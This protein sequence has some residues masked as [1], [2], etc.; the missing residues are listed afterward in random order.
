MRLALPLLQKVEGLSFFK[1]LG[2]G[3]GDGFSLWPD[4]STYAHLMV[5]DSWQDANIYFGNHA[6][7]QDYINNSVDHGIIYLK[8]VHGHGQWDGQEPFQMQKD[9][10][11]RSSIA[12]I[13]RAR[14]RTRKLLDFWTRVPGTSQSIR[15][16]DGVKFS[17]GIG[18]L[19]VVQQATF[20]LWQSVEQMKKFAYE[21]HKHQQ[22]IKKTRDH[23]WYAEEMFVRF[24]VLDCRGWFDKYS[25]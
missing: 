25:S 8:P 12:V 21:T 20:S 3:A 7:H 24:K 16:A 10:E 11:S 15:Q 5:W 14:I 2:C 13:T 4:F 23:N 6:V 9:E 18:E 19:P 22:V 17:I 1:V